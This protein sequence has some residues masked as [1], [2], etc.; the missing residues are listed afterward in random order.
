V[1]STI[2]SLFEKYLRFLLVGLSGVGVN[3]GVFVL[4][5]GHLGTSATAALLSSMVAFAVAV[6]WNFAWNYLW[7]FRRDRHRGVA[8]HLGAFVLFSL[9]GL[10]INEL[11]LYTAL[12]N[13]LGSLEAQGAGILCG[14]V[15]NF[16]LNARVNF[17]RRVPGNYGPIDPTAPVP[18]TSALN[19][20]S[21]ESEDVLTA[22]S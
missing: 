3:L 18:S 14:S 10:A 16:G 20:R 5:E 9:L 4:A 17:A 8:V 13:G 11:V 7:T 6:N 1:R 22:E 12:A 19:P 21:R 2:L 15:V